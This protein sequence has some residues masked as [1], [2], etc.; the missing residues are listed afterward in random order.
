MVGLRPSFS[1]HVRWCERGAPVCFPPRFFLPA[2]RLK[3]T[4]GDYYGGT[5]LGFFFDSHQRLVCVL[6]GKDDDLGVNLKLMGDGKKVARILPCH[7]GYTPDLPFA[8]KQLVVVKG[9]HLV[10]MNGIDRDHAAFTQG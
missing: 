1:A 8:P 3:F 7:V 9:R 6:Q 4:S 10:K 5:A 2:D